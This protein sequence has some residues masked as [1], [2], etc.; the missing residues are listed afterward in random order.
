MCASAFSF[1]QIGESRINRDGLTAGTA[2]PDFSLSDLAGKKRSIADYRGKRVLLIFSD[3]SCGPCDELA[4]DLVE[5]HRRKG[6]GDNLEV[7]MVS[8]GDAES[9]QA[10]AAQHGYEF[11]VLLQR[12][13]EISKKYGMFATP[14]A[15]LID[16]DGVIARD[17]A[18]GGKAILDLVRE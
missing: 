15:Y 16:E 6:G 4:P 13:W 9:N 8:R 11:P 7:V 17:V 3:T 2:A 18:V 12:S 1:A 14:I 5:L 10:K